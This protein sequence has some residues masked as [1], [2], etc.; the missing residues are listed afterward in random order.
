MIESY[1]PLAKY[2]AIDLCPKSR[3]QHN[4]PDLIDEANLTVVE[5][6][7]H[8]DLTQIDDLT[9]YL[10]AWMR[11]KIKGAIAHDGLVKINQEARV[12][13]REKGDT[14]QTYALDHL[15]SLDEKMEW[16][17]TDNLEEPSATPITPTEAAPLRSSQKRAQVE[18]WLSYL[19]PRAQ[20]ILHLRYGLSDDNERRHTTKEIVRLL[21]IDRRV[22]LTTE[23][24]AIER[25]RPAPA[26]KARQEER[27]ALHLLP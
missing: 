2:F 15:L 25:L 16:F 13:A 27:Q 8:A 10:V 21:G 26:G 12:R 9:S 6:I 19:S 4:L 5:V 23:R 11:G 14:D 1:L 20:A 24:D 3:Y 7:T 17:N 22:V 18:T